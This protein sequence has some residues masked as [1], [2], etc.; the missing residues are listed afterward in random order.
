[1][2]TKGEPAR[3]QYHVLCDRGFVPRVLAWCAVFF[4]LV[5]ATP[6]TTTGRD[7]FEVVKVHVMARAHSLGWW[8][9]ISLLASSC[10]AVQLAL[11]LFSVGCAG[12]NTVLGPWRPMFIALAVAGQAVMWWAIELPAVQRKSAVASTALTACMTLLPEALYLRQ[13]FLS[14]TAGKTLAASATTSGG[15]A[16]SA[17]SR[18]VPTVD[19][20]FS[21]ENMGCV[22]CVTTI[23]NTI[24]G[25]EGVKSCDI[26]LEKG[27]AWVSFADSKHSAESNR[28]VCEMVGEVGFPTT[29]VSSRKSS[30]AR[31]EAPPA[32]RDAGGSDGPPSLWRDVL[33]SVTRASCPALLRAP[34]RAELAERVRRRA[35]RVRWVQ[36]GARAIAWSLARRHRRVVELALVPGAVFSRGPPH[37]SARRTSL[38]NRLVFQTA[39]TAADVFTRDAQN[40]GARP[41]PL[42]PRTQSNWSLL[43][44]GSGCEAC[45]TAATRIINRQ[46]GVL[47]SSVDF[48]AGTARIMVAKDWNFDTETLKSRLEYAGYGLDDA[49]K[50]TPQ[51]RRVETVPGSGVDGKEQR[52]IVAEEGMED[53]GDDWID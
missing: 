29:V 38:R 8:S 41:S 19:V 22:A 42:Q 51:A 37:K 34:A 35:R 46:S 21:I 53:D 4:V 23:G 15:D 39:I 33:Q 7:A 47:W 1:M 36:Q 27:E 6:L 20:Q 32:A 43:F 50:A 2:A 31:E 11:N 48:E 24:R 45:E 5:V 16:S 26:S 9:V 25:I 14:G 28:A 12:L 18:R 49:S 13:K 10:C 52:Q 17:A 44:Q 3:Y 40:H 30:A